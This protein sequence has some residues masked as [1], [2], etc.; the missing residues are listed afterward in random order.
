M[1]TLRLCG[2]AV[3]SQEPHLRMEIGS[4]E[5]LAGPPGLTYVSEWSVGLGQRHFQQMRRIRMTTVYRMSNAPD[6]D[7]YVAGLTAI[8]D[9]ISDLQLRLL[10]EQYA[11][12]DRTVTSGGLARLVGIEGGHSVVNR[13]YGGLGHAFCDELGIRPDLRPDLTHR[14]WSVWSTGWTTDRGF[15]WRMLPQ[16]AEAL[17]RLGWVDTTYLYPGELREPDRF[18]EGAVRR[19]SVNAYERNPRA[20]ARC[21]EAYGTACCICGTSLDAVYGD[22]AKGFI[23]VHHLR[24]LSEIAGEYE[25]DPV[26]DLRPVCPDCH[27]VIHLGGEHRSIEEVRGMLR[28]RGGA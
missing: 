7:G 2:V 22:A 19:V 12:P 21:I 6:V 17:K 20:R 1:L 5:L 3:G 13:L 24:P 27:A 10:Q 26:E 11:A 9:R 4:N 23:H 25:V 14:W 8:R 16:V 28:T 18:P 15:V